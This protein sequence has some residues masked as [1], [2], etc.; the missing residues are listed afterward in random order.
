MAS[1]LTGDTQERR[2]GAGG[3]AGTEAEAETGGPPGA[4]GSWRGKFS[5]GA[6]RKGL[7]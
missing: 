2:Q 7:S 6:S 5:P 3:K 1:V 4:P